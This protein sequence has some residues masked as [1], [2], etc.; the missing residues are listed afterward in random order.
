[1]RS[2]VNELI[3]KNKGVLGGGINLENYYLYENQKLKKD[4]EELKIQNDVWRVIFEEAI[5]CIVVVNRDG[6]VMMLNKAYAN[7]L[8]VKPEEAIGKHVT[9]VIENTRLHIVLK[10]GKAE[11]GKIQRIK[12][13]DSVTLRIPIYRDD[14]VVGAVGKVIYKDVS[15]V[16]SLYQKLEAAEKELNLYKERFKKVKGGYYAIDNIIGKSSEICRLKKIV[17]RVADSDS[18]VLITGE[19]GTGKEVFANA[20]HEASNRRDNEYI[21]INCA[22]IPH[23]LLES[24]LFGYE[25]GAFTGARQGG[26]IGKFELANQGTLFLDEIGDMSL[27]MQAKLLRVLQEKKIERVGGT[28][29]IDIDVRIIAATNQNLMEKIEKGEFREDLFYRLNVIP[30]RIP[31]LRERQE[32]IPLLCDFFIKKYNDKFGIYIENIEEEAMAYLKRYKWPGNVRELENVI[33]RIYNFIDGNVIKKE[34]LPKKILSN[35]NILPNGDLKR[36]MDK[37]EKEIIVKTL[38]TYDGNKSITAKALGIS[39]TSLYQKID[40]YEII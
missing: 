34:H 35:N 29:S 40:K 15:E 12:N 11:I 4:V 20:I 28:E 2:T 37:Y 1:M 22:A 19:S 16:K 10:T 18:T 27:E 6:I 17:T 23:N 8:N 26:K 3:F 36:I 5:E 7:F 21:K 39:R 33:E 14:E 38:K 25:E 30:L 31:P 9:N 24:E 32:D 13:N